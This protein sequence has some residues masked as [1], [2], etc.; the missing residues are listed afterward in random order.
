[1]AKKVTPVPKGYRTVT[2][3]LIVRGA[4]AAIAWYQDVFGARVL[5]RVHA[6][7]GV[8]VLHAEIKI[9]NA[10]VRLSD[11]LPAFG[12]LSPLA[13]GGASAGLHVYHAEADD[14]WQAALAAGAGVLV[15]FADT[16][17][18]E[19]FGRFV[20]PFG[21]VWSVA[22]RTEALK[23]EE[24]ATRAAEA[25]GTAEAAEVVEAA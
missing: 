11:E 15:P 4:D 24:I 10:Q 3:T 13:Y 14:I 2:P 6:D 1:M 7:D 19:R 5:S 16:Y 9:G 18:G 22:R 8:T 20:D 21:H 23:P 12:V 17:W 25:F